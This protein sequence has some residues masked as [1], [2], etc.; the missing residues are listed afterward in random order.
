MKTKYLRMALLLLGLAVAGAAQAECETTTRRSCEYTTVAWNSQFTTATGNKIGTVSFD[1]RVSDTGS[2][3]GMTLS[4]PPQIYSGSGNVVGEVKG[5][6]C[7]NAGYG[8][9]AC[10]A[11]VQWT[12]TEP[13]TS[14]FTIGGKV[15][16]DSNEISSGAE[17][18]AP[19]SRVFQ[20]RFQTTVNLTGSCQG[21][22]GYEI[23]VTGAGNGPIRTLRAQCANR[24]GASKYCGWGRDGYTGYDYWSQS[25]SGASKTKT[26]RQAS[27]GL[28]YTNSCPEASSSCERFPNVNWSNTNQIR[29][30]RVGSRSGTWCTYGE[31]RFGYNTGTGQYDI[32]LW[33]SNSSY[34][35]CTCE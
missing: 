3:A 4:S 24:P 5:S 33:T 9:T 25:G 22:P 13:L 11:D 10:Y 7:F 6:G 19:G 20:Q 28:T 34:G 29:I 12:L 18:G 27:T 35:G 26:Y 32:Y 23:Y 2:G 30:V 14:K 1:I 21:V 15:G 8:K 16:L 31:T 17:Y